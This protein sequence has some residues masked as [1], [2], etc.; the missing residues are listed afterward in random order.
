MFST[1][2][3]D[4]QMIGCAMMLLL[5][6]WLANAVLGLFYNTTVREEQFDKKKLLNGLWRLGTVAVG[7]ALASAVI[8]LFPAYLTEYGI[9]V[10]DDALNTFRVIV[11]AGLY[12]VAI[13]KYLKECIN[14]LTDILK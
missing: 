5:G 2:I 4:M 7:T 3:N 12:A 13:I 11:I 1:F 9:S 8:S 6:A 10:Q 14:K